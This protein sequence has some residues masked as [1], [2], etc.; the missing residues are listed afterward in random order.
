MN[1]SMTGEQ[2][3]VLI[4]E[5]DFNGRNFLQKI[6]SPFGSADVAIDGEE[7]VQAFARALDEGAPY[8]LVCLDIM[9]PKMDGHQALKAIRAMEKE[10]QIGSRREAKVVMITALGDPRDIIEAYYKGGADAYITKPIFM[11]SLIQ[12]IRELGLI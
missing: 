3:R 9:M 11:N 6:L 1:T 8:T 2:M 12:T 7:A 10:R 4:A 5:D